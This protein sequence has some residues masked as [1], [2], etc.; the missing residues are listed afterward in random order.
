MDRD[1]QR[2]EQAIAYLEEHAPEQPSLS[3]TAAALRLSPFHFQRL[4]KRYAGVSPKRFLQFCTAQE[5]RRLLG[6]STP[7]L[8]A[9]FELGLSS[10]SRL[11][12]LTLTVYA[13][14]PGEVALAGAGIE[15]R[16][17]FH[18][19]PFGRCLLGLSPR[20]VCWLSFG[21]AGDD[22]QALQDLARCWPKADLRR[23]Q[24]ATAPVVAR[25]FQPQEDQAAAPLPLLLK[26]SNFQLQVWQAL[27]RIPSGAFTTYGDLA[28]RLGRP[29]AARAVGNAAGA[30]S[31]A[32]LIPC[33]RVLRSSGALGGY[34]WGMQRKKV[35]IAREAARISG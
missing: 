3:Q 11:H 21:D 8:E 1:Y 29:G 17:G 33:H 22:K 5:A 10:P 35:M 15:I 14:T 25:I 31:I 27:L 34:R 23:D 19:T 2:I 28:Q 20:G 16:H 9:A 12:D 6:Q 24:K 4:F 13:L 26:G 32:Y 30:N 18:D 7:V